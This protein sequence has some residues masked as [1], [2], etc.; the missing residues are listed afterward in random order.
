[1]FFAIMAGCA[2][3]PAPTAEAPAVHDAAAV[4]VAGQGER[5]L[6]R[7]VL[8]VAGMFHGML[9]DEQHRRIELTPEETL[10]FEEE[11]LDRIVAEAPRWSGLVEEVRSLE[12]DTRERLLVDARLTRWLVR[13]DPDVAARFDDL[14]TWV[15]AEALD[16]GDASDEF[17]T[18]REQLGQW[19]SERGIAEPA[20]VASVLSYAERCE[21]AGVP[22]PS[23]W[24]AGWDHSGDLDLTRPVFIG[25]S[26][27]IE[28]WRYDEPGGICLALPR[29]SDDEIELL[30]F[31]CQSRS[32]AACFWDNKDKNGN[33]LVV[34]YEDAS[35]T[36]AELQ[37][38]D[39]LDENCTGCHRGQNAFVI[40]P[41]SALDL[42]PATDTVAWYDPISSNVG[43][44]NP[45]AFDKQRPGPG[46][47]QCHA[48]GMPDDGSNL[49]NPRWFCDTILANA[50]DLTMPSEDP[51][52]SWAAPS[53]PFDVDVLAMKAMCEG[54]GGPRCGWL[55]ADGDG[56]GD[57]CDVCL[58]V[59]DLAQLDTDG[60][61]FGDA[62]DRDDDE[63]GLHDDQE[64]VFGTDPL[65]ADSDDDGWNDDYEVNVSGT[66]PLVWD[67]DG[68]Q[69]PDSSDGC[70]LAWNANQRD[71]DR[72][73]VQ[74]ACDN[75]PSAVNP[76][77][78]D[79]EGDGR[80]D[81]CD[82]DDD[83]DGVDDPVDNCPQDANPTQEDSDGD[84]AGDVCDFCFV[85]RFVLP[86][87]HQVGCDGF[88]CF[89]YG[90]NWFA[91]FHGEIVD[92]PR[93]TACDTLGCVLGDPRPE[94]PET[95]TSGPDDLVDCC[96]EYDLC[97]GPWVRVVGE[98]ELDVYGVD[99]GADPYGGFGRAAVRIGD[100]DG[101]GVGDLA[102]GEPF[103][104]GFGRVL[105]VSG[106]TGEEIATLVGEPGSGFG[107][108]LASLDGGE[109]LAVGAPLANGE[110]GE[111][112]LYTGVERTDTFWGE[113]ERG[114]FGSSLAEAGDLEGDGLSELWIGAP[115]SVDAGVVGSG[116]VMSRWSGA[117][118]SVASDDV[119]DG[120]GAS[121][122]AIDID[123]DG[124]AEL[125][126]GLPQA[127]LVRTYPLS[128]PDLLWECDAAGGVLAGGA[129]F[130]DD[131]RTELLVGAPS[132]LA[133]TL[134]HP[135][136]FVVGEI[137]SEAV[138]G[139]YGG[140]VAAGADLN[141]DGLPDFA[142]GEAGAGRSWLYRSVVPLP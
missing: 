79:N 58:Q 66:D 24:P 27:R 102:I 97:V 56:I 32:G 112:H 103:F 44:V 19:L 49:N 13:E 122:A 40:H 125:A 53:S 104:E 21:A 57:D 37:N 95:C 135:D 114:R 110:Y 52:T 71:R 47:T 46:C 41:G 30:G 7:S 132:A 117:V 128:G 142:V 78:T 3:P 50:A 98:I 1:M 133:V 118:L 113:V 8:G 6:P 74:D 28:V 121:G 83:D 91:C 127:G 109:V 81:V 88:D 138:D 100:R 55:D 61:T 108:A 15:S 67:T 12:L 75:C 92:L 124:A 85:G 96:G 2:D 123:G 60:D 17:W 5:E 23:E 31:I 36:F 137:R 68:D 141:G 59:P 99:L 35:F 84:G 63:D 131:E 86:A 42:R 22:V 101:D 54:T 39:E 34:P 119:A 29:V 65:D 45:P 64:A 72:D 76:D 51:P 136:G 82:P 105:I 87:A 4:H 126:V 139:G 18:K 120:F 69:H 129:S 134:V 43:W 80:G 9:F 48:L 70:P 33:R 130:V 77:Q 116:V 38:G 14:V 115:G 73:G 107:L 16:Q 10:A 140:T 111:V 62:C 26:D 11:L 89:D 93:V 94:L 25:G 106:T 20:P 90:A